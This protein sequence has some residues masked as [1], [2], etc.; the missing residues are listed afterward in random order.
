MTAAATPA[1]PGARALL[2]AAVAAVLAG[3][4]MV[5]WLTPP[6]A[7]ASAVRIDAGSW[8]PA[9]TAPDGTTYARSSGFTGGRAGTPAKA[10]VSG[11][12][13]DT[14]L[15]TGWIGMTAWSA[16]VPNG[17]YLVTLAMAETYWKAAGKRVFSATVEGQHFFSDLDLYAEAG[18]LTELDKQ[19][20][21]SVDDAEIDLAFSASVDLAAV[22][23]V[24]IEPTTEAP[25]TPTVGP[26]ASVDPTPTADPT[27]DP[28]ASQTPTDDPSASTPAAEA[29]LV[30][31]GDLACDPG[32]SS[33]NGGQGT[34]TECRQQA[35]SDLV[36]ADSAMTAFAALGDLQYAD[37]TA[38]AFGTS[39]DPSYGR[40]LD[41]TIPVVGNH[42]Y[43]TRGAAGYFGYF[44]SRAGD[45]A[46]GYYSTDVGPWHV[47][48]LNS[49]C[50]EVGCG[51][52]S[53]QEQWLR[54]D[55]A[56][57][58][59]TCTVALMHHPRYSS[60]EHGDNRAVAD[61]WDTLQQGGADLVLA[62]H[63]HDYERFA[64][65]DSSGRLNPQG[66]REFVVG[67]G[68]KGNRGFGSIRSNS[69]AHDSSSF[70]VL[71]LTLRSDGYA[72]RFVSALGGT[73]ADSGSASCR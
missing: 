50:G 35:V 72:W 28:P 47:V 23:A 29:V 59:A 42:E 68:G 12:L 55:L 16:P 5:T 70:G 51:A 57:N 39:Y 40:V 13:G 33:F 10:P 73:N 38:S 6:A 26:S 27:T 71:R 54:A 19:I 44:G 62:G 24:S 43:Q 7:S 34:R 64:P 49:N 3:V 61:L 2:A 37:G 56:A 63:D 65:M 66:M 18:P 14:I 8:K 60:G 36:V 11:R 25:A 20:V 45:P 53:A 58:P 4:G 21:V 31:A 48:V 67:T 9:T 41:R 1:R 52:G 17:T 46:T 32:S 30:A 15:R 69:E 22:A